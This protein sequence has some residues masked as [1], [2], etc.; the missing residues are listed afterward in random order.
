MK[1][2]KDKRFNI[3]KQILKTITWNSL[4]L[5]CLNS[6][7]LENNEWC[8]IFNAFIISQ[9]YIFLGTIYKFLLMHYGPPFFSSKNKIKWNKRME[10]FGNGGK[11]KELKWMQAQTIILHCREFHK[12]SVKLKT[13]IK[14]HFFFFFEKINKRTWMAYTLVQGAKAVK[15]NFEAI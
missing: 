2:K 8:R 7:N 6:L 15:Q 13:P 1:K 11:S 4:L 9:T 12:I 3:Y 10:D 5:P 14:E